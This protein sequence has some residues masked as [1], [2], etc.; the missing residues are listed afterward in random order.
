MM[1]DAGSSNPVRC[2]NLEEWDGVGD[3]RKVLEEGDI[4]IAVAGLS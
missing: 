4:G 1:Y 2:D 3:G